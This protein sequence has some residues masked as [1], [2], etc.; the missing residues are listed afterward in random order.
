MGLNCNNFFDG[1]SVAILRL[2]SPSTFMKNKRCKNFAIIIFNEWTLKHFLKDFTFPNFSIFKE[3]LDCKQTAVT[4]KHVWKV[5]E[6]IMNVTNTLRKI[7]QELKLLYLCIISFSWSF[8]EK[9]FLE[10]RKPLWCLHMTSK[11]LFNKLHWQVQD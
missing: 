10:K 7:N 11:L 6:W 5:R 2:F 1:F 3:I 8:Y 9:N 4:Y